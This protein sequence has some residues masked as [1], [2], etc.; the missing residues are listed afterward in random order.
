MDRKRYTVT[1]HAAAPG[2]PLR[3]ELDPIDTD[4]SKMERSVPGH[5]FYSTYDGVDRE[6]F[7]F[8]P[9]KHGELNGPG[10]RFE[11]DHTQYVDP[12]YSRTM[13]VSKE[14]FDKLNEFGN[15]A[16]AYGFDMTYK[17]FRN[18][19]VDYTWAALNHAGIQ[20][21][22][23][24]FGASEAK[25]V[26]GKLNYLPSHA[27]EDIRTIRDPMPGSELNTETT[28]PLP[29]KAWWQ[30]PL[31]DVERQPSLDQGDPF[32]RLVAA[33]K[34]G[35]DKAFDAVGEDF[36]QSYEGKDF[37]ETG[38]EHNRQQEIADQALAQQQQQQQQE[39]PAMAMSM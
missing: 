21:T 37:L 7:G 6:S 36:L 26:D 8:A 35:D 24:R 5:V 16:A 10:K 19:C 17:D 25:G 12:F 9:I 22:D 15:D 23:R 27:P 13:E 20:R 14:Q 11:N 4:T 39:A 2:T 32:D 34:A 18:N 31:S 29:S 33:A 1:I 3:G 38:L 28:N 30:I